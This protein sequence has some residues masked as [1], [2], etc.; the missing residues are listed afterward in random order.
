M[1]SFEGF[2]R[3][4]NK[5]NVYD[6]TRTQSVEPSRLW[7]D[8][9]TSEE[10]RK[11]GFFD[12]NTSRNATDNLFLSFLKLRAE[13]PSVE[14]EKQVAQSQVCVAPQDDVK[15]MQKQA[16]YLGMPYGLPPLS[17]QEI[18][19]IQTWLAGG[20]PGPSVQLGKGRTEVPAEIQKQIGQWEAFLNHKDLRHK[21]V[22]RYLY[23]HLFL[24]H[25]HFPERKDMFFRL[26]R[27]RTQCQKGIQLIATRRPN[28]DPK[29]KNFFYCFEKFPGTIVM[30]T[31]I[32]YALSP[33]KLER[34]KKLFWEE[35]WKVANF[36]SYDAGVAENPFVAYKDIPV[37]ARYQ[38]LLDDAQYHV[39]TFIKGPVCNGSMAVNSIQEQFYVFFLNPR[40]DNMVLSKD[41]DTKV[42]AL[43]MLPGVFGSD[44]DIKET[45]IFYKKL[46]DHRE[47]YRKARTD[48][49]KK[50]KPEGYALSD[51]WNGDSENPNAVL[52][53]L[54]HDDNAVVLKGAVGDLSKTMFV[55]DYPL[56]ERLVYNLVVNFDVFGNVSHQLLTRVYM[57]M[58]RMEAEELFLMF[59]PPEQRLEYRRE[60][61]KG[62]LTQ[63]KMT[64]VYPTVGSSEPTAVRFVEEEKDTKKQMAQKILFFHFNEKVRGPVDMVNWKSLQLPDS[65]KTKWSVKGIPAELR[66]IA[67]VP[68]GSKTPFARFF[69]DVAYLKI[70]MKSGEIKVYSL[71]HNKE[72][73]SVSWILAESLRMAPEEDTLTIYEGFGAPYPNMIF[74]VKEDDLKT[75]VTAVSKVSSEKD[76][77][78][79]VT[80]FGI[81]RSNQSFWV[82]YDE[83]NSLFKRVDPVNFGYLDLT[84]YELK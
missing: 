3:G 25:L 35:S 14:V 32:P 8:A 27:S 69:P 28:D 11:R 76:Y 74:D 58:I 6:G 81:R 66:K 61:Y 9:H 43:L 51:I 22:S 34:I 41:Y 67:S 15:K 57:D 65:M 18:D 13:H 55:L 82:H 75:F 47:N 20:A 73:E 21:L 40:S 30:K 39:S 12:L 72:H 38:F 46:V 2:Q 5:L 79:L 68:A 33:A 19:T 53:V 10:W 49:F 83:L 80:T 56:F 36:P 54:R 4:A 62:F 52:T 70:L 17:A 42:E 59:L 23:E 29:T 64:Y 31:H 37:K 77:Q 71:I 78:K 63:V 7:V 26:V 16:P 60:W 44:V 1:Q 48:E 50:L 84:R 45:P 24:G